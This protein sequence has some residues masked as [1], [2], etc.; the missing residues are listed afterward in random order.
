M[1][2]GSL[3]SGEQPERLSSEPSTAGLT[4]FGSG[5][6]LKQNVRKNN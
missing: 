2:R 5:F 6:V 3:C 4:G 1:V